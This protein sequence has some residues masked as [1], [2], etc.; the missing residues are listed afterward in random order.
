VLTELSAVLSEGSSTASWEVYAASS[1]QEAFVL[2][3]A[4][5][6]PSFTGTDWDIKGL[7]YTQRPRVRG[8]VCYIKVFA[9]G[10]SRWSLE[11]L[12]GTAFSD[13]RRRV[14]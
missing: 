8:T 10:A 2:A 3:E 7:N 12:F 13:A 4:G 14:R 6:A 9:I 11:E 1:P 5:T